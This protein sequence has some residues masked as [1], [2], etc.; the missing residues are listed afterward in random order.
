MGS[1]VPENLPEQSS[2][3]RKTPPANDAA[4]TRRDERSG[5]QSEQPG[6]ADVNLK[7]QG[8]H[9]NIAQNTTHQGNVQDR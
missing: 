5:V 1:T 9:G 6:D 8:R 3:S 7:S 2:D 4:I